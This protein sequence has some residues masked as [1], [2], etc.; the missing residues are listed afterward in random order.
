MARSDAAAAPPGRVHVLINPA[1]GKEKPVLA[2][3]H[4]VLRDLRIEWSATV[5]EATT[6]F[7]SAL[8]GLLGARD[9]PREGR[10][11]WIVVSGGDGTVSAVAGAM[12]GRDVPLAVLPGGTGNV[13]AQE[14]GL[15]LD[16]ETA[17]LRLFSGPVE[18]RSWDLIDAAGTTCI[19]RAG[20]GADARMM[21][22]ADSEAKA[23]LGWAAYVRAAVE[24]V[25]DEA[26]TNVKITFETELGGPVQEL[27]CSVLTLL[28]LNLSRLGRGGAVLS[29][30]V[31]PDDGWLDVVLVKAASVPAVLTFLKSMVDR[32]TTLP[33][34]DPGQLGH[35]DL[36]VELFRARRVILE[37]SSDLE[38]QIDGDMQPPLGAGCQA[39]F[40][41]RPGI[42]RCIGLPVI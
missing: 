19:L 18:S 26:L 39:A 38:L 33:R 30:D 8:D 20:L 1:S 25:T 31:R 24:Q 4:R 22:S 9:A 21:A 14:L 5:L 10:P 36:P 32:S 3:L 15:P 16:Y 17:A 27:R 13:V 37:P 12:A 35:P 6:D 34:A 23:T 11:D 42:V 41:V 29:E 40:T 28:I 7:E 2:I